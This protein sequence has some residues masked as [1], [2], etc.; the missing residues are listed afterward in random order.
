MLPST[1][2]LTT[3]S[4]GNGPIQRGKSKHYAS[5][6]ETSDPSKS[7]TVYDGPQSR[8]WALGSLPLI[9]GWRQA[10]EVRLMIDRHMDDDDAE[11]EINQFDS[12]FELFL[13]QT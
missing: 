13:V 3:L 12:G 7:P 11:K 6:T 9:L 8:I 10:R 2:L 1:T 5:R 4:T